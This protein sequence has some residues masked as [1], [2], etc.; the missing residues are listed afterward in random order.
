MHA[1]QLAVDE[2]TVRA[3]LADQLPRWAGR[4]VRLLPQTGTVNAIVRLGDDLAARFPLQPGDPA[5][6]RRDLTREADAARRLAGRLRV[7]VPE[8]VAPASRGTATRCR[9]R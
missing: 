5:D 1:G 6:V 7:G 2:E 8:V 3:L 4:A 9:G